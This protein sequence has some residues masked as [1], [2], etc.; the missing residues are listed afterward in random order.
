MRP[1]SVDRKM[2]RSDSA[3]LFA[4]PPRPRP[5]RPPPAPC[6]ATSTVLGSRG[7]T[8]IAPMY[9]DARSPTFVQVFPASVDLNTPFPA[10]NDHPDALPVPT[11]TMFGSDGAT[12]TA[13]IDWT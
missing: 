3:S 1:P 10:V 4:A 9:C 7:M 11:Y 8:T 6:A 5:P 2:P 12:A 13:P